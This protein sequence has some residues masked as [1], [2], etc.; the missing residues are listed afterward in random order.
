MCKLIQLREIW[1][2]VSMHYIQSLKLNDL[3]ILKNNILDPKKLTRVPRDYDYLNSRGR[4]EV[5]IIAIS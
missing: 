5:K 3:K 2:N 1:L 4:F